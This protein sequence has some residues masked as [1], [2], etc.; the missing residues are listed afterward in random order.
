M[1]ALLGA[2]SVAAGAETGT[3]G[4]A[5]LRRWTNLRHD[6]REIALFALYGPFDTEPDAATLRKAKAAVEVYD[7]DEVTLGNDDKTIALRLRPPER[8]TL[9]QLAQKHSGKWVVAVAPDKD[10][11]YSGKSVFAV[12]RLT[13]SMANGQLT[14]PH[15][16]C[17][18]I[19]RALR[20]R[21]R[22]A[23]FRSHSW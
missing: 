20:W 1:L 17:A 2:V 3:T 8:R 13:P 19:A 6:H 18:E 22:M 11:I 23:E 12:T 9:A 10:Q 15:P 16:Q 5:K 7:F 21:F 14:F 4:A